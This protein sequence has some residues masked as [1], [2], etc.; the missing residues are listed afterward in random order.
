MAIKQ[1]K[2]DREK[3]TCLYERHIAEGAFMAPF[4]NFC[5]PIQYK[6]I[7][8][9]HLAVRHK[10][11]LFDVSHMGEV[12]VKGR[13]YLIVFAAAAVRIILSRNVRFVL[14][15]FKNRNKEVS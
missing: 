12:T 9:E 10:C 3:R 15:K 1:E 13:I 14:K 2:Q 4:A 6:N 8:L 7:Q 5:M 11:G